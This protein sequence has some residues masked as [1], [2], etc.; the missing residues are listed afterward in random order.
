MRALAP[1]LLGVL[2]LVV[3]AGCRPGEP[4]PRIAEVP[5]LEM[6]DQDGKPFTERE[7]RGRVAVVSFMFTSCPDVCPILTNKLSGLRTNLLA[8]RE[9]LRIVSISVDPEK[10]TPEVLKDFAQ[11]HG[12]DYPDWRFLTGPL[13]KLR[14]VVVSG[15]KQSLDRGDGSPHGIMHG[16]HLVLVDQKGT[17]RGFYRSDEEG[18]LLIARDARRLIAG[19]D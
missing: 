16:S 4:L 19:K 12:A 5:A 15:F 3:V 11:K 2:M 13:A 10:D 1:G 8:Q 6:R 17:I 18:L 14:D 7:L 9:Q